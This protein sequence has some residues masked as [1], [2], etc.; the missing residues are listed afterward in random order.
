[1]RPEC[2]LVVCCLALPGRRLL[3]LSYSPPSHWAT[4]TLLPLLCTPKLWRKTKRR[5]AEGRRRKGGRGAGVEVERID[6][7]G[8]RGRGRSTR[9]IGSPVEGGHP[10]SPRGAR[11]RT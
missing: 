2:R 10:A 8:E 5:R 3:L 9:S 4:Q 7:A 11:R 6:G 1:M